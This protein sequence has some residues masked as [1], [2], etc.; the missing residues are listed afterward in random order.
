MEN[1]QN[2]Q[3]FAASLRNAVNLSSQEKDMLLLEAAN[4]V[5][6]LKVLLDDARI[7]VCIFVSGG[8][9]K[10]DV[11]HTEALKE[12]DRRGWDCMIPEPAESQLEP[13]NDE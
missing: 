12:A 6:H 4:A 10:T 3:N 5:E 9:C 1:K 8:G 13:V 11:I 2:I 7:E